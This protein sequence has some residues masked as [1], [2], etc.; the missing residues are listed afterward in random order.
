[1]SK[2]KKSNASPWYW[3]KNSSG[4]SSASFTFAF[5]SF[6]VTTIMYF[7]SSIQRCGPVEFKEFDTTAVGAYLV[8]I[9]TLYFGRRWTEANSNSTQKSPTQEEVISET[10][11]SN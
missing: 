2:S 4:V 5:I 6:W 11:A 10:D 7:L 3:I 1:M 9:L 8:P